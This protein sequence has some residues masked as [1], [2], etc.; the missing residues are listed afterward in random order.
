MD[1]RQNVQLRDDLDEIKEKAGILKSTLFA[2]YAAEESNTFG[3]ELYREALHGAA[4]LTNDLVQYIQETIQRL[5]GESGEAE[6]E[7]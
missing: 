6:E 7:R 1:Q 2:I 4:Y 3:S 5:S